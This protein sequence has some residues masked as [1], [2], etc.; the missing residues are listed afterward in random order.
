MNKANQLREMTAEQLQHE[1]SQ[2]RKDLLERA[3][4]TSASADEG[5]P[6]KALLR[7]RI[8]RLLTVLGEKQ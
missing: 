6:S 7:R 2:A 4:R 5:G 3:V 8:A 1:L